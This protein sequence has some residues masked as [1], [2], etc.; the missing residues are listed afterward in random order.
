MTLS[1]QIDFAVLQFVVTTRTTALLHGIE[2]ETREV[3]GRRQCFGGSWFQMFF[4]DFN[5]CQAMGTCDSAFMPDVNR[6]LRVDAVVSAQIM[7][8]NCVIAVV[9]KVR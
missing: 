5:Y 6:L 1:F 9:G 8:T 4:Y 2:F 3:D 7:S